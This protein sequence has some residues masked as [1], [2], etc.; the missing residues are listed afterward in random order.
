MAEVEFYREQAAEALRMAA[1]SSLPNVK[2]RYIL[3]AEAW[4]RF[5]ERALGVAEWQRETEGE[6]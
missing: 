5:S 4:Q 3:A 6:R 1:M 2:A